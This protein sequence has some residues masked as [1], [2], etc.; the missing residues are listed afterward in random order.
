MKKSTRNPQNN[1][2]KI[3]CSLLVL[4]VMIPGVLAQEAASTNAGPDKSTP[5]MLNV[6]G[7]GARIH[8]LTVGR[9][10]GNISTN[11]AF[12]IH[13]LLYNTSGIRNTAAGNYALGSN[14]EGHRNTAIGFQS[15]YNNTTGHR[16]T[17]VG[18][19]TLEKNTIGYE[20]TGLG[21][22]SMFALTSGNYNTAIGSSAG[23]FTSSIN[24]GTFVGR[25]AYPSESGFS[26]ITGIGFN[27]RPNASNQVRIGNISV[28]SIGGQ[29]SWTVLSDGDYKN[30]IEEEVAGLDFILKLRPVSYNLDVHRLA[31]NLEEDLIRG[32]DGSKA[33]AVPDEITQKSRDE[34]AAIRYTGF[35]AQEVEATVNELGVAFS[36]VDAPV[37]KSG[38]YG[39]R[40]A[41][42]VV[43]LVKA[44]QEQQAQIEALSPE[45]IDA[46]RDEL[47]ELRLANE[48]LLVAE[49][50]LRAE[51]ETLS[52]RQSLLE[53]ENESIRGQVKDILSMLETLGVDM[54]DCC[55]QQT[56][57]RNPGTS[58]LSQ[59]PDNAR[60]EQN[61][62]NPFH[63]NTVI[64]YFLPEG[65]NRAQIIITDLNGTQVMALP[66]EHQGA[67]QVLIHGG[68]LPS[69]TYVYTLTVDGRR[70]E[71][72][73][74][75]LL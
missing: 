73:R 23:D 15:L 64:R 18:N 54:Q 25:D 65:T 58:S 2:L 55:Q 22:F 49:A 50:S 48:Q 32:E 19:F 61:T 38:Y 51:N 29:V 33:T 9:G 10:G 28:T 45:G 62:P 44:V 16:N 12:G 5:I 3:I 30:N 36:G 42:F 31:S 41:D 59:I 37:N 46:L 17:A 21:Y 53:T 52:Q 71:S 14:T 66:L 35:V 8:D 27:A 68:A 63:E 67:G 13:A 20:N 24:F 74:M 40:Y 39:L 1:L 7:G 70:V 11:S 43:P 56:T 6:V 69:G 47:D 75:V 57:G 4:L 26:N 60:L 72:K 34:K